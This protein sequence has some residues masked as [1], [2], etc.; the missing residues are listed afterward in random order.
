M[1][2]ETK[3]HHHPVPSDDD[4]PRARDLLKQVDSGTR[5]GA[6][7]V[8]EILA[9]ERRREVEQMA[10]KP[11]MQATWVLAGATVVL[12]FATV[13]LIFANAAA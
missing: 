9:G 2:S 7:D 12:A 5:W 8:F 3:A 4:L 1:A 6:K 10:S 11:A 13:A